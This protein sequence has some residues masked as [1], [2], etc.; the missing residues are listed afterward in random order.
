MLQ[1]DGKMRLRVAFDGYPAAE[2]TQYRTHVRLLNPFAE[3]VVLESVEWV[4]KPCEAARPPVRKRDS[5]VRFTG[6]SSIGPVEQIELDWRIDSPGPGL[7]AV[8]A[9][10]H[11]TGL[12]SGLPAEG[13]LTMPLAAKTQ[14]AVAVTDLRQ[15]QLIGKALQILS[16]RRGQP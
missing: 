1:R 7:C 13:V 4:E 14:N 9:V 3:G 6:R 15:S 2:G 5:A 12:E 16:Q 8:D 10:L 11:G